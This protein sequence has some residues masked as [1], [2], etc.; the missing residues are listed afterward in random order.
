MKVLC[1]SSVGLPTPAPGYS[2]LENI[3]AWTA[4]ELAK[5]GHDVQLAC[6][7][8]SPHKKLKSLGVKTIPTCFS[9]LT[10]IPELE[11]YQ[12]LK[13]RLSKE[14]VGEFDFIMDDSHL[15]MSI[16]FEKEF[17]RREGQVFLRR[18]HDDQGYNSP[19]PIEYPSFITP[20]HG[21]AESVSSR[22]HWFV[23]QVVHHG[24]PVQEY[25]PGNGGDRLL[26][27]G[28]IQSLKGVDVAVR[29][30]Q[31]T[32][33][34]LDIVGPTTHLQGDPYVKSITKLCDGEQIK[35]HGE[36]SHEQKVEFYRNALCTLMPSRF[37]E[38]FGLVSTESQ[39]CGTP[40]IVS[41]NGGLPE[42]IQHGRTGFV[43][44]N[45]AEF[46]E[47]VELVRKLSRMECRQWAE[48]FSVE[49]MVNR[50]LELVKKAPW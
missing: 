3:S 32:G 30:A 10:P 44:W 40:M 7:M 24:I 4:I 42:T 16:L 25:I 38:P 5:R 49:V 9:A 8:D 6:S 29:V 11:S 34:G 35:I 28:R 2:G 14:K 27:V 45:F 41:A 37:Q 31:A 19:P 26:Y 22:H 21:L 12:I 48:K 46:V 39:A 20:S 47:Y 1:I 13:A 33:L 18:L 36:V 23:S 17:G 15:S 43:A 50:I